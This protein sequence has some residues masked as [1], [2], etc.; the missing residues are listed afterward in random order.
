ME[1]FLMM[2]SMKELIVVGTILLVVILAVTILVTV[3]LV[4]K[5]RALAE[6]EEEADLYCEL[7]YAQ[8]AKMAEAKYKAYAS[9]GYQ[10]RLPYP[11]EAIAK[12]EELQEQLDMADTV[13]KK[14]S[15]LEKYVPDI[16]VSLVRC[17]E[18]KPVLAKKEATR[19]NRLMREYNLIDN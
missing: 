2:F 19:I 9:K 10:N 8:A 12:D 18:E 14:K 13:E 7:Y 15:V 1:T 4:K 17:R 6:A 5:R 16:L 3:S 11:V